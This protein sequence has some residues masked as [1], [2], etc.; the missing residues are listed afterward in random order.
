MVN[1]FLLNSEGT[2][3]EN[4]DREKLEAEGVIFALPTERHRPADGFMLVEADPIKGNDGVWRQQWV[5]VP[6]PE[7]EAP[8]IPQVVSMRQARLALLQAGLLDDVEATIT[9]LEEPQRTATQIEWEYST[10]V[11]RASST[12]AMLAGVLGLTKEQIDEMFSTAAML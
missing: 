5:E 3:P 4:V 12:T 9:T 7:R 1:Q 10:E 11:Q 8:V 2:W 6:A